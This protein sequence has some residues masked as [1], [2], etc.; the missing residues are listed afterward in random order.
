MTRKIPLIRES[1]RLVM[2]GVPSGRWSRSEIVRAHGD[3]IRYARASRDR[4]ARRGETVWHA[5]SAFWLSAA[6]AWRRLCT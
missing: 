4:A 6:A 3:C 1:Q 2:F 5:D